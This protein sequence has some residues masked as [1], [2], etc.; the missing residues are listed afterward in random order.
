MEQHVN[1]EQ[2]QQTP[3]PEQIDK[4]VLA[5][6]KRQRGLTLSA[7]LTELPKVT[8][9]YLQ[10]SLDRLQA[11]DAVTRSKLD[12]IVR[13][14]RA[15]YMLG[16]TTSAAGVQRRKEIEMA[17]AIRNSELTPARTYTTASQREPWSP[18][19]FM[20]ATRAGALDFKSCPSG[21]VR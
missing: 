19:P 15:G 11:R 18:P 16:E 7:L 12:G 14:Y 5:V 4:K 2:A 3:P 6:L 1:K 10:E 13:F 17:R 9:P 8:R 20:P 21:G